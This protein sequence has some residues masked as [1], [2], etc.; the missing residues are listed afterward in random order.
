MNA[1]HNEQEYSSALAE[2]ERLWG[3]ESREGQNT[4]EVVVILI[5]D[6]EKK[7]H[8][9][10]RPDP[11]EAL[12][13][14]MEWRGLAAK[15]LIPFIGSRSHVSEVLN[16]KRKLSIAMI[17][18]LMQLGIPADV[19]VGPPTRSFDA[20]AVLADQNVAAQTPVRIVAARSAPSK[21]A[22]GKVAAPGKRKAANPAGQSSRV[23]FM[24]GNSPARLPPTST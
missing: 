4:L 16:G 22:V 20:K 8:D 2:L 14:I 7:H 11:A 5:E 24:D 3:D 9:L 15:D 17:A 19:L 1:I 13:S 6:Y 21:N 10:G 23:N 18:N 12:K